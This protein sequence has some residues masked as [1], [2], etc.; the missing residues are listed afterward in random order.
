MRPMNLQV[1]RTLMALVFVSA[2]SGTGQGIAQSIGGL[3]QLVGGMD[4]VKKLS[5]NVLQSATKDPRL[6]GVLGKMDTSV[7]TPKLADQFC[8]T[9]GGGC[10]APL[11]EKQIAT[12]S[13]KLD[14]SQTDALR[15]HFSSALNTVTG[16]SMAKEA[17]AKAITP[18]LAGM[19]GA[20]I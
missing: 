3:F 12:G 16:N 2:G 13:S 8:A 18:K 6:A 11:T 5:T 19:V 20:L 10:K 17:L 1:L 9:L 15:E 4:T 7:A 14:A